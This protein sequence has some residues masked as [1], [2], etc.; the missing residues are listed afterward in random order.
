MKYYKI[1]LETTIPYI[2]H[3]DKLDNQIPYLHLNSWVYNYRCAHDTCKFEYICENE[4][5]YKLLVKR[6]KKRKT[7][8]SMTTELCTDILGLRNAKTNLC[9]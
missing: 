2:R 1:I 9:I 3:Y 4:F 6:M 7:L 8:F 5:S